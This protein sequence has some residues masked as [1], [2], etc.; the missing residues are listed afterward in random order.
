M[1]NLMQ[2]FRPL[3][4][5]SITGKAVEVAGGFGRWRNNALTQQYKKG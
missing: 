1:I 5:S 3:A 4:L 2:G